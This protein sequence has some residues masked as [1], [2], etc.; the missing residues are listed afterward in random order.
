VTRSIEHVQSGVHTLEDL[1]TS[2]RRGAVAVLGW[3]IDDAAV[4]TGGKREVQAD[5]QV[6]MELMSRV[7]Q[8]EPIEKMEATL[9]RDPRWPSSCCAII[10]SA[11]FGLSVEVSS[12]RHA[13][14][15]AGLF[16]A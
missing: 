5:L 15:A 11:A 14:H 9:R 10:N 4:P 2:F 3:P 12:F 6:I 13:H 8:G 1:E 16:S 7:D